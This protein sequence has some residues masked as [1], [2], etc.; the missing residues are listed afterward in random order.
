MK[1]VTVLL[2]GFVC[3]IHFGQK[4]ASELETEQQGSA[5]LIEIHVDLKHPAR[6]CQTSD[7]WKQELK[8]PVKYQ[9]VS[10]TPLWSL[11]PK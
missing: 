2:L 9:K 1:M 10:I 8:A 6:G 11:N 4:A 3:S 7:G 5:I